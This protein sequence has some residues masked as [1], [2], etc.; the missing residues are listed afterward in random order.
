ML[1]LCPLT[2][3]RP[4]STDLLAAKSPK[5]TDPASLSGQTD[6]IVS[7]PAQALAPDASTEGSSRM[8]DEGGVIISKDTTLGQLLNEAAAPS[9]QHYGSS[10]GAENNPKEKILEVC[11]L[12]KLRE[13]SYAVCP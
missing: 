7:A 12:V 8:E 5:A 1:L 6:E 11:V 9:S 10:E 13:F 4:V 2:L 3:H